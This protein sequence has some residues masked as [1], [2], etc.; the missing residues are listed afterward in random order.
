VK[1]T[2]RLLASL[3]HPQTFVVHSLCLYKNKLMSAVMDKHKYHD[4][5]PVDIF[6]KAF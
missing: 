1:R 2:A 3:S 4:A 5:A 6:I